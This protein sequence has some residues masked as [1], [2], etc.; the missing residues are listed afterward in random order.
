M[1][2]KTS[3]SEKHK[4]FCRALIKHK[5]NQTKAYM[6]VYPD[7][8]HSSARVEGSRLLTNVNVC[9]YLQHLTEENEKKELVTVE[10]VINSLK[11]IGSTAEAGDDL[12][13]ARL[14]WQ[15]LGK[16][17]AMFT[18]KKEVTGADGGPMES[19]IEVE[20]VKGTIPRKD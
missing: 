13:V 12:G 1:V 14:C 19:K 2:K 16:A 8:K 11:R 6:E 7:V 20:F 15:D 4:S 5:F 17:I 18:D 9:N 10:E 3:I